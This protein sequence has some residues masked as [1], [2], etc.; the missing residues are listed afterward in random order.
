VTDFVRWHVHGHMWPIFNLADAAL[1]VGVTVLLA[2]GM[3]QKRTRA[4]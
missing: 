4:A 3:V 1:L 2:D